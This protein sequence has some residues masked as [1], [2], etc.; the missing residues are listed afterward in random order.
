MHAELFS[1]WTRW[2]VRTLLPQRSGAG[3]YI[4]GRMAAARTKQTRSG[5]HGDLNHAVSRES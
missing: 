1:P 3:V 5:S 4:L 2:D